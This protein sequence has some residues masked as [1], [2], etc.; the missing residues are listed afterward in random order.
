MD[1][2]FSM[3]EEKIKKAVQD[4]EFD[5]LP[6]K[7]KPLEFENLSHVPPELR[8]SYKILKNAGILPEEMQ[9][10]KDMIDL[11]DLIACCHDEERK[12]T[13]KKKWNEKMLQF[14]TLMEKRK[15]AGSSAFMS[16]QD[17]IYRKFR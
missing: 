1:I 14:N 15:I 3:A 4:G 11:E 9:L 5:Q 7:G 2:F 13:L 10:K 8:A 12:A 6:G 16:Y 17:K